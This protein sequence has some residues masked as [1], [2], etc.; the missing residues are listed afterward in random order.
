MIENFKKIR[1]LRS[2][3]MFND[4]SINSSVSAPDTLNRA[5][6]DNK[7]FLSQMGIVVINPVVGET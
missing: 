3:D 5:N 6:N 7:Y 1:W 4:F 2:I